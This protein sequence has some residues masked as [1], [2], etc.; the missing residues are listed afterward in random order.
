MLCFDSIRDPA[1]VVIGL[2][3]RPWHKNRNACVRHQEDAVRR[4]GYINERCV[5]HGAIGVWSLYCDVI[6]QRYERFT[7]QKAERV[8]S[9]SAAAS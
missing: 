8:E 6:V 9:V 2:K 1:K 7:G 4:R 5:P 3:S